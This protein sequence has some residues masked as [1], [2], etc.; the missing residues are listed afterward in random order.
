MKIH[1][2]KTTN[3]SIHVIFHIS[4]PTGNND[5]G[6]PWCDCVKACR[7]YNKYSQAMQTDDQPDISDGKIIEYNEQYTFSA[8]DLTDEEKKA[9]IE[10]RYLVVEPIEIASMEKKLRYYGFEEG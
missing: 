5:V 4:V 2:N 8:P 9:E 3:G 6:I 7:D 1:T 10:A